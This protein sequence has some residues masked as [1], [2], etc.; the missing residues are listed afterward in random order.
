MDWLTGFSVAKYILT[1]CITTLQWKCH[2]SGQ[3][4][5]SFESSQASPGNQQGKRAQGKE[6][7]IHSSVY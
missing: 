3:N 6:I 1:D 7:G 5:S 2:F 4:P